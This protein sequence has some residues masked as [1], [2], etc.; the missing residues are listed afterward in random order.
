MRIRRHRRVLNTI[1]ALAV[2]TT[3]CAPA[4]P[5]ESRSA[6]AGGQTGSAPSAPGGLRS[7]CEISRLDGEGLGATPPSNLTVRV[8][9]T[10][11]FVGR[12]TSLNLPVQPPFTYSWTSITG[13]TRT[14]FGQQTTN[15][16]QNSVQHV[17][18]A[19]TDNVTV[20]VD[21][22]A[23]GF[24]TVDPRNCTIRVLSANAP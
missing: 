3:A 21:V 2:I 19:P 20:F 12:V 22:I 17:F 16:Q 24:S 14:V 8:G 10:L 23:T 9:Q 11:T 15:D 4:A 6:Q 5:T 18:S 13:S 7:T 1:A